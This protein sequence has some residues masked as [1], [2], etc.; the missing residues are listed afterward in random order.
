MTSVVIPTL[1]AGRQLRKLLMALQAQTIPCEIIIIDSASSDDTRP[2]AEHFGV[3]IIGIRREEFEHGR[4]RTVAAEMSKGDI[5]VYLTQ[6]AL[7][8]D[9]HALERLIKPLADEK[10]GA[11]FGRQVPTAESTAFGAH[12]R[13]FNY[14]EQSAVRSL[15]DKHRYG[16]K[17]PFLS[18]SFAAYKKKTLTEIGGFQEN[19][20]MGEDIC[21][22]A[23]LLLAGYKIAY[24]SDAVVLHSHNYTVFQEFRRY[25]D[26]GVFHR[27]ERWI[28]T[29]F[30]GAGGEG[31][32]YIKS[33]I[34]YLMKRGKHGLLPE[35][36]LRNGLKFT[37][38]HLGGHYKKMP[39]RLIK[40]MSMH[41][42]WWD[43]A[44]N[45]KRGGY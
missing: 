32:R 28:L 21:A 29:Q 4:S 26:I 36:L 19:L 40:R 43:H 22:G 15:S 41:K 34:V 38:Y 42:D 6:D 3:R 27:N 45:K 7:P 10:V 8:I 24:V 37:A 39:L 2:I 31:L 13:L 16:V 11:A 23:R 18:N 20:I 35:F 30:G 33:E 25:F 12:L 1:N 14:P 17:T 5:V 9:E 44:R